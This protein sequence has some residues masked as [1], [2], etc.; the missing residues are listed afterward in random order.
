VIH[1]HGTPCGAT[2][3]DVVNF[4]SGRHAL[5][6]FPRCED[7]GAA[8]DV[9]QSFC[10]D[11]GAFT[12]W[13]S[14]NPVEK[15]ADY[16]QWVMEWMRHPA[17]DFSIIPDVIDGTECDNDQLIA[18]WNANFYRREVGAPVWHLHESLE[19][20]DRLSKQWQRICLGSSGEWATPGNDSWWSRMAD[21]MAVICDRQGRP[22]CKIHG[23][24]MLDPA[25]FT[26]LPLSS[27]DSTNAVRNSSGM[28]RFGMY[29]PPTAAQRMATIANRIESHQSAAVWQCE[30]SQLLFELT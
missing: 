16:Y 30:E 20:L 26:K 6:P 23:L 13:K 18:E 28:I 7:I 17:F 3:Q 25:I 4:L 2:R 27:A 1:Y 22:R 15:W 11:N 9:C 10:L 14:G 19:R 21:A 5:I 29:V 24:R 8:A 12:A